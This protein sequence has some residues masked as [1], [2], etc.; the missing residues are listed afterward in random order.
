[1][2]QLAEVVVLAGVKGVDSHCN[3]EHPAWMELG[4]NKLVY[5]LLLGRGFTI[6]G[7]RKK[8]PTELA[9]EAI[10]IQRCSS[11]RAWMGFRDSLTLIA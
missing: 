3:P 4:R 10:N 8:E 5:Q 9:N 2:L 1:L 7:K 6:E 11:N